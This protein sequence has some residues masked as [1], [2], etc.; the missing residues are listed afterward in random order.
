MRPRCSPSASAAAR[1]PTKTLSAIFGSTAA[2]ASTK[3]QSLTG[4]MLAKS[5]FEYTHGG[6]GDMRMRRM[7]GSPRAFCKP[8]SA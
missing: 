6:N 2:C 7:S 4:A 3:C 1:A 8:P 5:A